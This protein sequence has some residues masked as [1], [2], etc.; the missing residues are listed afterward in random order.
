MK[1]FNEFC[2]EAYQLNEAPIPMS[3]PSIPGA[4][5]AKRL[6]S[7]AL[8][9]LGKVTGFP[10]RAAATV[11][12]V[13]PSAGITQKLYRGAVAYSPPGV[14]QLLA[15][16]APKVDDPSNKT[17]RS[18]DKSVERTEKRID[19]AVGQHSKPGSGKGPNYPRLYRDMQQRGLSMF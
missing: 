4:G 6:T 12:M 19:K 5:I 14:S 9:V 3:R 18:I 13:D 8:G 16:Q 7:G 11:G 10:I 17:L 15:T 1:T 2:A